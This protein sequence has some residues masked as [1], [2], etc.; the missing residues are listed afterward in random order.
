LSIFILRRQKQLLARS[1][2]LLYKTPNKWSESQRERA[3]IFFEEFPELKK[4]YDYSI[5]FRNCY[6]HNNNQFRFEEWIEKVQ[7]SNINELKVAAVSV[8]RHLVGIL[9]YFQN[10]ST[11]AEIESFNSKLKFLKRQMQG[12]NG[13]NFF[14]YRIIKY[15]A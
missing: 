2:Y 9:N 8:Q 6:E 12:I 7:N 1:R 4:A 3:Q 14:F 11:N 13:K 10:H 15:F 5:Y